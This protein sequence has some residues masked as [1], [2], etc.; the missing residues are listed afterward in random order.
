MNFNKMPLIDN[1]N[2]FL[3]SM[4]ITFLLSVL[5]LFYFKKKNWF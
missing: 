3:L 1:P 5:M 2:G 4:L